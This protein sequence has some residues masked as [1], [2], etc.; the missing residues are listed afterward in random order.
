MGLKEKSSQRKQLC[1]KTPI[2]KIKNS[3][4]Y[5]CYFTYFFGSFKLPA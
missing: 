2:R 1:F 5:L 4:N 3:V